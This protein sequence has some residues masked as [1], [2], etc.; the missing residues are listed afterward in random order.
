MYNILIHFIPSLIFMVVIVVLISLNRKLSKEIKQ[1]RETEEALRCSREE[2][3]IKTAIMEAQLNS[4]SD[5]MIIVDQNGNRSYQNR[6]V[7]EMWKIPED[8][9]ASTD[10]KEQL[11]YVMQKTKE[12]EEF[13]SL[14]QH[15]IKNKDETHVDIIELNDGMVLERYTGP[16]LGQDGQNYGRIWTFHDITNYKRVERLLAEEK[17]QLSILCAV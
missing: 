17:E 2:L 1:S 5:G 11:H 9:Q 3:R 8:V 7:A 10:T 16:V 4:T 6:R 15:M 14:V 12:P 13:L